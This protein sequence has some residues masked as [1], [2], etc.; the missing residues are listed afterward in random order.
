MSF[1]AVNNKM[2]WSHICLFVCAFGFLLATLTAWMLSSKAGGTVQV[3][4]VKG[5]VLT[6]YLPQQHV[7]QAC[8]SIEKQLIRSG[9]DAINLSINNVSI[10]RQILDTMI[11]SGSMKKLSITR[12]SVQI[13][14]GP[15]VALM[16]PSIRIHVLQPAAA[17]ELSF[18][19]RKRGGSLP[20]PKH[21]S[22]QL[23][24]EVEKVLW[25][26]C[27]L[28]RWCVSIGQA[29]RVAMAP[30]VMFLLSHVSIHIENAS[31][32]VSA[33]KHTASAAVTSDE[34]E[35]VAMS[36]QIGTLTV[37]PAA[38]KRKRWLE[39]HKGMEVM[40]VI[41]GVGLL[42]QVVSSGRKDTSKLL[43]QWRASVKTHV[44]LK[45]QQRKEW[46]LHCSSDVSMKSI[47]LHCNAPI[48][49]TVKH[50]CSIL[51]HHSQRAP[52]QLYRPSV[53]VSSNP[54]AWWRYAGKSV[55]MHVCALRQESPWPVHQ[56]CKLPAYVAWQ[57]EGRA[58]GVTDSRC[59]LLYSFR[60]VASADSQRNYQ[61][62]ELYV[63]GHHGLCVIWV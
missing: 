1:L 46:Y 51:Q 44:Q 28:T 11:T 50:L 31:L 9:A 60:F 55:L 13:S 37:E 56:L 16:M 15:L 5:V 42:C 61:L 20:N 52:Y 14:V 38:C 40:T 45:W 26:P 43:Q 19:Q 2:E 36:A 47:L 6:A 22:V 63:A 12:L 33:P 18:Q 27:T 3:Y 8:N 21:V 62:D 4:L 29:L 32:H 53:P 30:Y 54:Q 10:S 49:H 35:G 34:F 17:V 23:L 41:G 57:K 59:M 7:A 24:K 25:P 58:K 48:F 39:S